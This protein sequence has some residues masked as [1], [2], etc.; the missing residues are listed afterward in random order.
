[1]FRTKYLSLTKDQKERGVIYSSAIIRDGEKEVN[2]IHEV[3]GKDSNKDQIISNLKDVEFFK[4]MAKE[5]NWSATN[6]VR[7]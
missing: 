4:N 3:F 2:N 1:M 5:F 7:Q 6:I